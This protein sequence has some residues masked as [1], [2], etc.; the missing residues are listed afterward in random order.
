MGCESDND[1]SQDLLSTIS[2]L[3]AAVQKLLLKE[4]EKN[5]GDLEEENDL[6]DTD[7]ITDE[8]QILEVKIHKLLN[9]HS[10]TIHVGQTEK[11]RDLVGKMSEKV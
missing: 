2:T 8:K 6:L 3:E 7:N 10:F 9:K 11:F 5:L 1:Q 4:N